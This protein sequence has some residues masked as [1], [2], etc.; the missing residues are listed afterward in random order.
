MGS[1]NRAYGT[2]VVFRNLGLAFALLVCVFNQ[3]HICT[4]YTGLLVPPLCLADDVPQSNL[5]LYSQSL[6]ITRR[7]FPSI[8]INFNGEQTPL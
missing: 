7:P 4:N 2:G 8:T 5:F 6:T 1:W 3:T